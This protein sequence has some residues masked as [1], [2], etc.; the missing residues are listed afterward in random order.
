MNPAEKRCALESYLKERIRGQD[1][2]IPRIVSV[3]NRGE[4]GLSP[5][6]RPK[7]SFLLLGPTGVGKTQT[8]LAFT[9]YLFG[10]GKLFRFDM[11]EF[12]HPDQ[13]KNLIGDE[14]GYP[15]RLG[16]VLGENSSGTLLFDEMEK[17]HRRILDIFLQMLD[18]GRVTTGRGVAHNL[19][20]FYVAMTSNIG[21]GDIMRMNG[22]PIASV[23]RVILDILHDELRP[24]LIARFQEKIVFQKL[25]PKAQRQIAQ[26]MLD[27]EIKRLARLGHN[28]TLTPEM[29]EFVVRH[30]VDRHHGVR[31]LRNM[32]E[33][34]LGEM[35]CQPMRHNG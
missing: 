27:L 30:G 1:H 15:G 10:P 35:A 6:G 14:T 12:Q 16:Q 4:L 18:A 22:L 11:S 13:I 21:G 3:L 2:I 23:E 34:Y 24:E 5:T 19:S 8:V 25:C 17:A 29:I 20:G 31:P 33:K 9:E 28:I 26:D 7:G 32:V